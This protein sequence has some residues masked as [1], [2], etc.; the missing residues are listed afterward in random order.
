MVLHKLLRGQLAG[1]Y[2]PFA[3]K[4]I[5]ALE[6]IDP[7]GFF[8]QKFR[9]GGYFID[10]QQAPPFQYIRIT[11]EEPLYFEFETSGNPIQT[12]SITQGGVTFSTSYK[13]AVV[14]VTVGEGGPRAEILGGKRANSTVETS[15]VKRAH[16]LDLYDEPVAYR[17]PDAPHKYRKMVYDSWAPNH[18]FTGVFLRAFNFEG[19]AD[20]GMAAQRGPWDAHGSRDIM[21]DIPYA[22]SQNLDPVRYAYLMGAADWPRAA[23][24]QVV[25]DDTYGTREFAIY[26]DAFNQFFAFPTSQITALLDADHD[27]IPDQNVDPMYVKMATPTFPSWVFRPTSKFKDFYAANVKPG[28]VEFPELDWKL[29][30]EGGA[31]VA[32]VMERV[33]SNYDT[34]YFTTSVGSNPLTLTD[35]NTF[36]DQN[37]GYAARQS[38]FYEAA[39]LPQRYCIAPGVLEVALNIDLTGP[40]PED[41]TFTI[42]TNQIRRPTTTPYCTMLAGY[43]WYDIKA[44]DWT[45]ENPSFDALAGDMV[46]LDIE[47]YWRAADGAVLSFFSLKKLGAGLVEEE[48]RGWR[49]GSLIDYD[50]PTLSFVFDMP[51]VEQFNRTLQPRSGAPGGVT[52]FAYPYQAVHKVVFIITLNKYRRTLYPETMR[53][54]IKAYFTEDLLTFNP[55]ATVL[56][57]PTLLLMPLNDL[58]DWSDT[59]LSNLRNYYCEGVFHYKTGTGYT[60]PAGDLLRWWAN[61]MNVYLPPSNLLWITAPRFSWYAYADEIMNRLHVAPD[62]TFFVHPEGTWA[63]FDQKHIYNKHGLFGP[64]GNHDALTPIMDDPDAFEHV[65]FDAVH[66]EVNSSV[67]D[68]SFVELYNKAVNKGLADGTLT[69]PFDLLSKALLRA[70][71][72]KTRL[73]DVPTGIEWLELHVQW[74]GGYN[75]YYPETAY[76]GGSY[77]AGGSSY[78]GTGGLMDLQLAALF[79]PASNYSGSPNSAFVSTRMARFSTCLLIQ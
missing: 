56:A 24:V 8:R 25:Q 77:Y 44:P 26:V 38:A 61:A 39:T 49:G 14:G 16:Q 20:V 42:V 69:Q 73:L 29:H 17:P 59:D 5:K 9:I 36:R 22:D 30:P 55:R 58:R 75:G 19:G 48:I 79:Y 2:L 45:E 7:G 66:L 67:V 31:A 15:R 21:Y 57:D 65:I 34:T 71:L 18:P 53:D 35:F 13:A 3:L 78:S 76:Q 1:I 52:A 62:S 51:Y 50:L 54:D 68:T 74:T 46:F 47:R 40:N 43:V 41:F 63:F 12:Q 60:T 27:G 70:D 4:R 72:I 32:V 64:V 10:V 33:A 23:G 37:A 11:Q 6:A 28:L